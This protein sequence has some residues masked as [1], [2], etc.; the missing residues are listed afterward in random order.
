MLWKI[1]IAGFGDLGRERV[2]LPDAD[3]QARHLKSSAI[4]KTAAAEHIIIEHRALYGPKK[5]DGGIIPTYKLN[6]AQY[7]IIN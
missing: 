4:G 2:K 5:K 6:R 1:V 3:H 7:C